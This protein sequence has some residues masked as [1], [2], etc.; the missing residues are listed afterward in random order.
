MQLPISIDVWL[1]IR[2]NHIGPDANRPGDVV[3]AR[4][5]TTIKVVHTDADGRME[6]ADALTLAARLKPDVMA[7]FATL[8]DA[9]VYSLGTRMSGVL[10]TAPS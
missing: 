5:G 10:P 8:T 7:D 2:Q 4:E 6:L 3:T 1:A 9:M